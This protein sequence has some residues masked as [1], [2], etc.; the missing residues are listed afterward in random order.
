MG[1][2]MSTRE[3]VAAQASATE[4]VCPHCGGAD[5]AE[6]QDMQ[7]S[8]YCKAY[9]HEDGTVTLDYEGWTEADWDSMTSRGYLTCRG[10][11]S[12]IF[13]NQL[14]TPTEDDVIPLKVAIEAAN[15]MSEA[16]ADVRHF[17]ES[18]LAHPDTV[19]INRFGESTPKDAADFVETHLGDTATAEHIRKRVADWRAEQD[20][21]R[22]RRGR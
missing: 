20:A 7:G 12:Q 10:C 22:E 2:G 4:L 17:L 11:G 5:F 21:R 18:Y 16:R 19:S 3:I 6:E 15:T 14:V 1:E 9:Q 8:S 13:Q